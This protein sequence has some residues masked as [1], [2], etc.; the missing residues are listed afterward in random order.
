MVQN[1]RSPFR[2]VGA[3]VVAS[4][5]IA[6]TACGADSADGAGASTTATSTR[7]TSSTS[8]AG[9]SSAA[10]RS[11]ITDEVV[12][13]KRLDRVQ[14]NIEGRIRKAGLPGASLL[15]LKDGKLVEQ[16][17]FG[18][19]ELDTQ[20]PIAS[21]SKW[22]TGV[23]IMSLVDDGSIDLDAP[24]STYLPEADGRAGTITMRQLVSFTS[25]LEYDEKIPCYND[26]SKTL[27]ACVG[28]ILDLPLLGEP[29]TG[30]RYT[31]THLFVAAAVVEAVTGKEY[32]EVFQERVAEPLGMHATTFVGGGRAALS[33][34]GH[35]SPAGGARSTLGDYGRFL[36][37]L[38][39]DG[40]APNGERIISHDAVVEMSKDQTGTA[41]FVSAAANRRRDKTKYGV[42]HWLDVLD[43]DGSVVLES[44]PGAFGFRPWIDHRNHIAGV[45]MIEDHDDSHVADAPTHDAQGSVSTSGA[46]VI[47]VAASALGGTPPAK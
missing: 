34:D 18:G 43:D 12:D 31:G 36:E 46:F 3:A 13:D 41:T 5:L 28:E 14:R 20:I 29:G 19:Y 27:R 38:V 17:A 15:I 42:A 21:A 30:F 33:A 1:R 44:S 4:A 40:V 39:H 23:V 24:I 11:A 47:A 22:L 6:L 10:Y 16:E 32:E 8:V 7:P 37:M 26:F 9:A 45:Y 35:P 2:S 25:G